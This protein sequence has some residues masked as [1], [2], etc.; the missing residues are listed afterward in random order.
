M[1][2]KIPDQDNEEGLTRRGH[3]VYKSNPS[4]FSPLPVT[5]KK[6][7]THPLSRA[8]MVAPGTGEVVGRG[9]FAFVEEK[10]VDSTEF[11]KI[12]LDGI[13]KYGELSRAGALLF[14]FVYKQMSGKAAKDKDQINLSYMLALEWRP[15]LARRTFYRGM[16][17][18]LAKNFLFRTLA[19]DLYFVNINF[20]FNGNRMTVARRYV[21]KGSQ[22][23]LPLVDGAPRLPAPSDLE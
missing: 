16:H 3:P 18:L 14:E 9:D 23:E 12:Y 21:L 22:A 20:M 11:V 5:I 19:A 7:Q 10:E 13:R 1:A 4:V 2:L 15:D 6:S 17:E 8:Y